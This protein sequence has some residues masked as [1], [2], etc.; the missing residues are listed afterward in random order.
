MPSMA[1]AWNN[2]LEEAVTRLREHLGEPVIRFDARD[3][4]ALAFVLD[5]ARENVYVTRFYEDSIGGVYATKELAQAAID[6][7]EDASG[8]KVERY[9]IRLAV[10]EEG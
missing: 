2:G 5:R 7:M 1:D 9:G 8:W 6:A 4:S 3:R 10:A